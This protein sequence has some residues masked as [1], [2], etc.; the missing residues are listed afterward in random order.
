MEKIEKTTKKAK[1]KNR[2]TYR[3]MVSIKI[4]IF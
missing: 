2:I 1:Y 3:G 4:L